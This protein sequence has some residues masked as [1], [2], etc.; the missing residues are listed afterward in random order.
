MLAVNGDIMI[1]NFCLLAAFTYFTAAGARAGDVILAANAILMGLLDLAAYVLD[2]IAH[3]SEVLVGRAVGARR[4]RQFVDAVRLSAMH[5]MG[6]AVVMS[7]LAS[8]AGP[9]FIALVTT[10]PE[11][12]AAAGSYLLWAALSPAAG[13]MAFLFDGVFT[14][15]TR[16]K[17]MRNMMIVSL[18]LFLAA[19][20]LLTPAYGNHGL[21]AALNVFFV[22]RGALFAA[23]LPRLMREAF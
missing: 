3:A 13:A 6:L 23:C 20:W 4:R 21:W 1:R 9:A 19:V 12:R 2:G 15:A 17:D 8:V 11:V 14:G 18:L 5:S 16:S 10:S 7:L 22:A